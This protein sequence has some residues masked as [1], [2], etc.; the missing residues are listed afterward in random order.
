MGSHSGESRVGMCMCVRTVS[1]TC[2]LGEIT[3]RSG[4]GGGGGVGNGWGGRGMKVYA[5]ISIAE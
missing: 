1:G 3:V 5:I 2:R 4:R